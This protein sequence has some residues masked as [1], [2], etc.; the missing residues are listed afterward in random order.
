MEKKLVIVESPAKAKTIGKFLGKDYII[1][2]SM[3]HV[4]DLPKKKFGVDIKRGFTAEYVTVTGRKKLVDELRKVAEGVETVYLAPDPDREGEAIAWHLQNLLEDVVDPDR[5]FRVTYQ[6]ITRQAII[7]AFNNPG[8]LDMRRVDSQ[9]ARRVLDRIVGYQVSPLLWRRVNGAASAGRV[10]SAALRILCEREDEIDKFV[11]EEYWIMGAN[12]RKYVA[13]LDPFKVRLANIDGKKAE[14]KNSEQAKEIQIELEGGNFVVCGIKE[15][16]MKKSARPPYIT[17]SL[18][19]AGSS[20]LGFTPSRT[21]RVA[22]KLYEGIDFGEGTEGLITYMRTDSVN[23]SNQAIESIRSFVNDKY[24]AEYLPTKPNRYKSRGSAQEAHEAIRPTDVLRTPESLKGCLENDEFRL[25]TLIWQRALASQMAPARIAQRT[26]EMESEET[27]RYLFRATASEVVFAGYM[28]VTGQEKKQPKEGEAE[29]E[30]LPPLEKD[31]KI[32]IVDW[33]SEQ[34]FTKPPPRFSEASLV[35]TLE[36][37]GV[38]RPST[39]AQILSTLVQRDYAEKQKRILAPTQLGRKTNTF[40]VDNLDKL[41]NVKFTA[42]MEE[43]LDEIESGNIKM[44]D[45]LGDFYKNF[46]EWLKLAKGPKG[47]PDEVRRIAVYLAD[48]KDWA[49]P[50]KR[51]KRTFDDKKFVH[52]LETLVETPGKTVSQR[53]VDVFKKI[54]VKYIDQLPKLKENA[55]ALGLEETIEKSK[56]IAMPADTTVRKLKLLENIK[57]DAPRKVGKRTYDDEDFVSSLRN[58]VTGGRALSVKQIQFLD[59]FINKYSDQIENFEEVSKE[60]LLEQNATPEDTQS[61]GLLKLMESVTEWR[62]PVK[63]GKRVFDDKDFCTSLKRQFKEK[64]SLS[65]RQ[66]YA[67]KRMIKKYSTQIPDYENIKDGYG[68]T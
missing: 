64:K 4:R 65:T 27:S 15:R 49:P 31:E 46:T 62:E 58:Q 16:E 1:R 57:F 43:K 18:Q 21:M 56:T 12:V 37:N 68:L 11:P 61:K 66:Q 2:A 19:Q 48:I 7:D 55:A 29:D 13:P 20:V 54:A 28:K 26:V 10:Q 25:Y 32:E 33:I 35:K 50:L 36:E 53:Q 8:E 3:G 39:Y 67:L 40:L 23:L 51:G 63:K 59:R 22:Q 14:V 44:D 42:E 41:F 34:K 24:G 5:F 45:M 9:Q 60:L 47:D 38:G 30:K 17:S 52:S 6:E